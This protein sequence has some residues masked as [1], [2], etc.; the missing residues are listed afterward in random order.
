[1]EKLVLRNTPAGG[2]IREILSVDSGREAIQCILHQENR[3]F[4]W[5][6]CKDPLSS[7]CYA[8]DKKPGG[9]ET[10]QSHH[11]NHDYVHEHEGSACQ[12]WLQE[13][14]HDQSNE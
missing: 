7:C 2:I 6:R 1:M 14:E 5:G 9:D 10:Y 3:F 11:S 13:Q 4:M 8:T 12:D